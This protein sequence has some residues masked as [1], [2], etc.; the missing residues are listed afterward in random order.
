MCGRRA[1]PHGFKLIAQQQVLKEY[2]RIHTCGLPTIYSQEYLGLGLNTRSV[3]M[4]S[5]KR[6]HTCKCVRSEHWFGPLAKRSRP[7]TSLGGALDSKA[8][9]FRCTHFRVSHRIKQSLSGRRPVGGS[10]RL[11]FCTAVSAQCVND[12][13]THL[14]IVLPLDKILFA[15]PSCL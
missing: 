14:F 8:V 6:V 5:Y 2:R 3:T 4:Q 11:G 12:D 15:V 1:L 10:H 13:C 9:E 7:N